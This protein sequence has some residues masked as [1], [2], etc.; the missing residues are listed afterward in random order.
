[1]GD[2]DIDGRLIDPFKE[3]YFE[4]EVSLHLVHDMVQWLAL[5]EFFY[6]LR[7]YQLLKEDS[8][9]WSLLRQRT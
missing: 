4:D 3:M 9:S 6:L 7:D 8:A 1:L 2:Q 5:V